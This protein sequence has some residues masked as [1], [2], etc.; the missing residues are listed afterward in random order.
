[1]Q[2][3]NEYLNNVKNPLFQNAIEAKQLTFYVSYV[4]DKKKNA[5]KATYKK[6]IIELLS[7]K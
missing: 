7:L 4:D 5:E 6:F 1:M 3:L 2:E